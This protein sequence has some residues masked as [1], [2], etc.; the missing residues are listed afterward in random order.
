MTNAGAGDDQ[1]RHHGVPEG[2]ADTGARACC[3]RRGG[4][5][6]ALN[7][8]LGKAARAVPQDGAGRPR[9]RFRVGRTGEPG[10]AAQRGPG[11]RER[12]IK[13]GERQATPA[14]GLRTPFQRPA[15][16]K[17]GMMGCGSAGLAQDQVFT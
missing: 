5:G 13:A 10:E 1:A 11:G 17:L 3:P 6:D 8:K 14:N 7:P 12:A 9:E 4:R 16:G 2:A 15:K